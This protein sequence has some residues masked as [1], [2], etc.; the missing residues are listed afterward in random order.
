A[1]L[2]GGAGSPAGEPGTVDDRAYAWNCDGTWWAFR[3]APLPDG[4]VGVAFARVPVGAP[5]EPGR[6]DWSPP[7]SLGGKVASQ[8]DLTI[9]C[10]A[11]RVWIFAKFVAP[12]DGTAQLYERH[13]NPEDVANGSGEGW[14]DWYHWR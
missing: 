3:A 6:Y 13:A 2:V 4:S 9:A 12:V 10:L 1:L 14:T 7:T 11:S 5:R 8:G